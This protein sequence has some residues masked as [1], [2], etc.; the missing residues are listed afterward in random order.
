MAVS[1]TISKSLKPIILV[2][3]IY[4]EV[5]NIKSVNNSNI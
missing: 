5:S 1:Y 3:R 2:D 4:Q